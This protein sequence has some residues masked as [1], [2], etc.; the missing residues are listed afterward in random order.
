M[1]SY[2]VVLADDHVMLRQGLGKMLHGA[3]D[4]VLLGEADDGLQLL[5]LLRERTP[6]LAIV[7]ISMP[8]VRGIE[9]IREA[10]AAQPDLAVIVLTMHRDVELVRGALAAGA[11]GYVLKEDA[12]TQLFAAIT[13]VRSGGIYI[14]PKLVDAV[15]DDWIR[16]RDGAPGSTTGELLSTREREV[17]KLTAEGKSCKE[18]AALLGIS[19]RTVEHH[20][21]NLLTKLKLTNTADLVRYALTHQYL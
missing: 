18:V 11:R 7:D 10:L 16:P 19:H 5:S 4:I 20:R 9:A 13:K 12:A 17:L 21:A 14:P 15:T 3:G 6:D 2:T 8:L 1:K